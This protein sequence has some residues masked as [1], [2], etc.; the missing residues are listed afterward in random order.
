LYSLGGEVKFGRV[1][2]VGVGVKGE[3]GKN[4]GEMVGD[5]QGKSKV[6]RLGQAVAL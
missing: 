1:N 2:C 5:T 3:I 4:T 6:E